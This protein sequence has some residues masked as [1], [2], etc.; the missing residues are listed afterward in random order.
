MVVLA[1]SVLLLRVRGRR[2]ASR[3]ALL[4]EIDALVEDRQQVPSS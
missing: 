4:C 2:L 1:A 3:A